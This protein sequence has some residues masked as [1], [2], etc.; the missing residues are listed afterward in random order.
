MTYDIL[1]YT[2]IFEDCSS[3]EDLYHT[4]DDLL[5]HM[6]Q[7]HATTYWSCDY[8]SPHSDCSSRIFTSSCDWKI[9]MLNTHSHQVSEGGLAFL[10]IVSRTTA[11]EPLSC[12]ICQH[13]SDGQPAG[14][15]DEHILQHLHEFALLS[16]PPLEDREDVELSIQASGNAG[17]TQVWSDDSEPPVELELR[18]RESMLPSGDGEQFL[19]INMFEKLMTKKT[20]LSELVRVLSHYSAESLRKLVDTI[21]D[22]ANDLKLPS[23]TRKIIFA[24]LVCIDKAHCVTVFIDE[25]LYDCY[26][27]FKFANKLANK[28]R[29]DFVLYRKTSSNDQVQIQRISKMGWSIR[30]RENFQNYQWRF[31]APYFEMVSDGKRRWPLHYIFDDEQVLPFVEDSSKEGRGEPSMVS[32]GYSD[33]WRVRI[34]PAHHSHPSVSS[35]NWASQLPRYLVLAD[36]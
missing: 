14:S 24:T 29:H 4:S 28:L 35:M 5:D 9:H 36:T 15:I 3:P 11:L 26:L 19:P 13:Q 21:C 18:L 2:C 17:S 16:L 30:E 1:P 27:P 12:P 32:G 20:I 34:H 22:E 33:V 10:E 6:R 8:C 25:D 31:L 23:T 7:K